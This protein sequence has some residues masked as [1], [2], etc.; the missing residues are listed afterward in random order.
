MWFSSKQAGRTK[1][2]KGRVDYHVPDVAQQ[3]SPDVGS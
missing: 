3:Y 1:K 2:E